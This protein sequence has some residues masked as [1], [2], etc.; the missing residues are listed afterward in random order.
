MEQIQRFDLSRYRD[1]E[2]AQF[3]DLVKKYIEEE[4]AEK[5]GIIKIYPAYVKA[6]QTEINTINVE[7]GSRLT[8][9]IAAADEYRDEIYSA[10]INDLNAKINWFDPDVRAAADNIRRIVDQVGYVSRNPY[11][12][13]SK[14]LTSLVDQLITNYA[15]DLAVTEQTTLVTKLKEANDDFI[16]RF[17]S[18]NDEQAS[19]GSGNV[20]KTRGAVDEAYKKIVTAING[21]SLVGDAEV[22]QNITGKINEL[23]SYYKNMLA[24]RKAKDGKGS[25]EPDIPLPPGA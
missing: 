23:I 11:P 15:G 20:S 13:E 19:R 14:A 16:T 17:G 3:H 10:F 18:R 5:L 1:K 6:L 7:S 4:T 22:Y 9:G 8:S 25:S 2:H 21:L 12:E 24:I